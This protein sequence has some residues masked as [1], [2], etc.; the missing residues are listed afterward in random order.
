MSE[1]LLLLILV[2]PLLLRKFLS[3]VLAAGGTIIS[4][5]ATTSA[6]LLGVVRLS[7][8]VVALVLVELLELTR[9]G[10]W[11]RRSLLLE[12]AG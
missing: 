7:L 9:H 4:C 5:A 6:G 8:V 10:G 2:L 1:R 12:R 3:I 11:R